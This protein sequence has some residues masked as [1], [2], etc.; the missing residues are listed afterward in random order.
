VVVVVVV[1]VVEL[2]AG[3]LV[4]GAVET[5]VLEVVVGGGRLVCGAVREVLDVLAHADNSNVPSTTVARVRAVRLVLSMERLPLR[6]D[7][8]GVL[9]MVRP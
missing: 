8:A 4:A 9:L 2:V 5:E 6:L 7:G 1:V 3:V